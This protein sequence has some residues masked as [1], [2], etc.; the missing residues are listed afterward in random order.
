MPATNLRPRELSDLLDE[1]PSPASTRGFFEAIA[2]ADAAP[3]TRADIDA[4]RAE[5]REL[6]DAVATRYSAL[7]LGAE[8]R[9]EYGRIVLEQAQRRAR[10]G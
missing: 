9:R 6:S 1:Q 3:A 5:V 2:K 4:L 7:I 10:G 8:A